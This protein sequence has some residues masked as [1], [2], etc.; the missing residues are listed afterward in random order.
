MTI[1]TAYVLQAVLET[2][3]IIQPPVSLHLR[4]RG[5]R[6]IEVC[7]TLKTCRH[8]AAARMLLPVIEG[9]TWAL[10]LRVSAW[11]PCGVKACCTIEMR[12]TAT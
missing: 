4:T 8:S 1:Q 10:Y 12:R 6:T 2:H 9:M 11:R 7:S 5:L 3:A